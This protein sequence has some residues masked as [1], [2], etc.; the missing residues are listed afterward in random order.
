MRGLPATS[1]QQA[2]AGTTLALTPIAQLQ[3]DNAHM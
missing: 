2:A 3:T 1:A